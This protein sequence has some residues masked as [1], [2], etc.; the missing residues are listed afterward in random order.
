ME[1]NSREPAGLCSVQRGRQSVQ[2]RTLESL[3]AQEVHT[4]HTGVAQVR[5]CVSFF[6]CSAAVSVSRVCGPGG[7]WSDP[8]FSGCTLSSSEEQRFIIFSLYYELFGETA[9]QSLMPYRQQIQLQ[10]YI[11]TYIHIQVYICVHGS[12]AAFPNFSSQLDFVTSLM[13]PEFPFSSLEIVPGIASILLDGVSMDTIRMRYTIS[14]NTS[15][16]T[17]FNEEHSFVA[18]SLSADLHCNNPISIEDEFQGFTLGP[19]PFEGDTF[20]FQRAGTYNTKF[21]TCRMLTC[22]CIH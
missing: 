19:I 17:T 7:F 13:L 14:Y 2:V 10:V 4:V 12:Y 21:G 11:Y 5:T 20:G 15:S 1:S 9:V 22:L 6:L 3:Y 18:R 16:N 8:N